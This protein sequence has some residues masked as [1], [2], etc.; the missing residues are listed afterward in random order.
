MRVDHCTGRCLLLPTIGSR[1]SAAKV[2]CV[3]TVGLA[4]LC[5]SGA[6]P[7]YGSEQ[8]FGNYQDFEAMRAAKAER[9]K[10]GRFYYRFPY[11]ESG[12]DV[13][14]R[15]TGKEH[16]TMA[17][18]EGAGRPDMTPCLGCLGC[19]CSSAWLALWFPGFIS[20]M[21]RGYRHR[22]DADV[23]GIVT[24]GKA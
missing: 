20:T 5:C 21:L 9:K 16:R 15:A 14:D 12:V 19:R 18:R 3:D 8:Q 11:G 6:D 17:Q 13:Y 24:H 4:P 22:G 1:R 7:L 10:F 23:V 2:R